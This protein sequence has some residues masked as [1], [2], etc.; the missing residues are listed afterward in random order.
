MVPSMKPN[1]C[2]HAA[3]PSAFSSLLD[4]LRIYSALCVVVH[5]ASLEWFGELNLLG[6]LHGHDAVIVFFVLSGYVIAHSQAGNPKPLKSFI[7]ERFIRLL[8]GTI[9]A[10]GLTASCTFFLLWNNPLH[11][12]YFSNSFE[13]IR[14]LSCLFFV[15]SIWFNHLT[16]GLNGPLWSLSYEFFYYLLFATITLIKARGLKMIVSFSVASL[17]GPNILLLLPTWWLGVLLYQYQL[18]QIFN[19]RRSL[20]LLTLGGASLVVI[21]LTGWRYPQTQASPPLL[22]SG[23]FISDYFTAVSVAMCLAGARGCFTGEI[24]LRCHYI[25]RKMGDL[26]FPIYVFHLP[27]MIIISSIASA[28]GII[29]KGIYFRHFAVAVLITL[30]F[31]FVSEYYRIPFSQVLRVLMHKCYGKYKFMVENSP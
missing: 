2:D 13:L 14:H 3:L 21:S 25:L 6:F 10:L 12:D 16:P 9:P 31:A 28:E 30:T 23:S 11:F 20:I 24:S 22:F 8:S 7:R 26:T 29:G 1:P 19:I 5:H 27:I 18:R 4:L 15:Q 17:A